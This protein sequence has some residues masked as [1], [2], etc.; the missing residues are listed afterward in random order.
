MPHCTGPGLLLYLELPDIPG[1]HV[2]IFDKVSSKGEDGGG[3]LVAS[4]TGGQISSRLL[5]MRSANALLEL[6]QVTKVPAHP[7]YD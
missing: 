3:E 4:S 6:P 1:L 5:S 2:L 7:V